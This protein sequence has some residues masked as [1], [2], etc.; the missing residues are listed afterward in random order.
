MSTMMAA[1][2]LT[3]T[4]EMMPS[5]TASPSNASATASGRRVL[6]VATEDAWMFALLF[7]GPVHANAQSQIID[8]D[9]DHSR[10][11]ADRDAD[12]AQRSYTT[13]PAGFGAAG[14]EQPRQR[15]V[16]ICR[17]KGDGVTCGRQIIRQQE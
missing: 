2:A 12:D 4:G 16:T 1:P 10:Q 7:V 14:D 11:S 8:G 13:M 5:V 9:R 3:T 17:D 15:D 6:D